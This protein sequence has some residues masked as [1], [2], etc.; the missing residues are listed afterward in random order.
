MAQISYLNVSSGSI[1]HSVK[2]P[3]PDMLN[4]KIKYVG[5]AQLG[6]FGKKTLKA[7]LSNVRRSEV[8]LYFKSNCDCGDVRDSFYIN[9]QR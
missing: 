1:L 5:N 6:A 2:H 7:S 9:G 3:T 8:D 4:F